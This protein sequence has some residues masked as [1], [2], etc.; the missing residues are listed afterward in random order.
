MNTL[1]LGVGFKK[2]ITLSANINTLGTPWWSPNSGNILLSNRTLERSVHGVMAR[3]N[4]AGYKESPWYV[5]RSNIRD[6]LLSPLIIIVVD[7]ER[8]RQHI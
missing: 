8:R 1:S 2:T 6:L 5:P 3:M 7:A 4:N